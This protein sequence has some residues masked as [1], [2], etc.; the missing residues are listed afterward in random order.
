MLSF[1]T[2][3]EVLRSLRS[4]ISAF[5]LINATKPALFINFHQEAKSQRFKVINESVLKTKFLDRFIIVARKLNILKF[6]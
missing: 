1:V 2:L 4:H 3:C 5:K 6:M